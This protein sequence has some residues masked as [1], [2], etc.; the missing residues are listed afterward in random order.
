[1][2]EKFTPGPWSFDPDGGLPVIQIYCA[3]NKNPF[4]GSRSDEEHVANAVLISAAP[5]LYEA[6]REIVDTEWLGGR[7]GFHM[8]R[9]A[10][11]KARGES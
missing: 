2:S 7:G 11:A 6:L 3:D 4:H 10:L 9:A 8:A 1:M 5:E